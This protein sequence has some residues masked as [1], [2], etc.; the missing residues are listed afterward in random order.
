MKTKIKGHIY[1]TETADF[2]CDTN[3]WQGKLYRKYHS[4]E[5]FLLSR[6]GLIITPITWK[7]ARS[8]ARNHAP[9]NMYLYLFTSQCNSNVGS[10][11]T[12]IDLT[13]A[14]MQK[15]KAVAGY[16]EKPVK[17]ILSELINEAYRKID[18]HALEI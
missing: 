7:E 13:R 17:V 18:R 5:Y 14:D 9:R 4:N 11:R 16:N 12:N 10:Q 2:I 8:I 1:N 6:N 3:S 15:I